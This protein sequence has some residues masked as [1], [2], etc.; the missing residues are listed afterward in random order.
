MSCW[1]LSL[2]QEQPCGGQ[3]S[4]A[5]AARRG[6]AASVLRRVCRRLLKRQQACCRPLPEPASAQN[7]SFLPAL[8]PR[9][10]HY[11]DHL[12]KAQQSGLL[13][14]HC[15]SAASMGT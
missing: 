7:I 2:Q 8:N 12:M 3:G 4:T 11:S 10:R 15:R 13:C 5:V 1:A 14:I 9:R 6:A